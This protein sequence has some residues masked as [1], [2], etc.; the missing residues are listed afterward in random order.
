MCECGCGSNNILRHLP[1]PEGKV[2]LL[3][4]ST[5]CED[6]ETPAG[7]IIRL[8][9]PFDES[10]EASDGE[11]KLHERYSSKEVGVPLMYPHELF[12]FVEKKLCAV[13]GV[14]HLWELPEQYVL[15]PDELKSDL[16]EFVFDSMSK[17]V[18]ACELETKAN[19][20]A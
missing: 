17:H 16:Y 8:T 6:C 14:K 5:A 18:R 11:L 7:V 19:G 9:K 1:G 10:L 3:E 15:D 4:F 13:F 20:K 2:Y 12:T